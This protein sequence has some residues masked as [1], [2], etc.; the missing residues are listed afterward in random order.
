MTFKWN[1]LVA[2]I[3]LAVW[4]LLSC[5]VP[6]VPVLLGAAGAAAYSFLRRDR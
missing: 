1:F 3:L 6:V 4:I 2:S 5:G